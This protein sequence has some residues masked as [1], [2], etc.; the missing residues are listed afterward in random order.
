MTAPSNDDTNVPI[1]AAELL[2]EIRQAIRDYVVLPTPEAEVAVTLWVAATHCIEAFEHAT[3][4]V[5]KSPV[6]GC[7]KSRLLEV[8]H[9]L[10]RQPLS[11]VNISEAALFRSIGIDPPTLLIDE[12]DVMFGTKLKAEQNEGVRGIL[13]AGFRRGAV[14][15]RVTGKDHTPTTFQTFAMAAIAGIGDMPGTIEDRAVVLTMR[16]RAEHERVRG[17]RLKRDVPRLHQL[18]DRLATWGAGVVSVLA[19]DEPV[20]PLEDRPAD[21][22]EPLVA[23]ADAAGGR[24]PELAR[25]AAVTIVE[26]YREHNAST[27]VNIRLL[28]DI[29][30]A[31]EQAGAE[32]ISTDA[33]LKALLNHPDGAWSAAKLNAHQLAAR[34]RGFGVQPKPNA[35]GSKR[36]YRQSACLDAFQRYLP[37]GP[38]EPSDIVTAPRSRRPPGALPSAPDGSDR[39][40]GRKKSTDDAQ[41]QEP[42]TISDTSDDSLPPDED[43]ADDAA[44]GEP[45]GDVLIETVD[46]SAAATA[47]DACD[48]NT[49]GYVDDYALYRQADRALDLDQVMS[50]GHPRQVLNTSN[51]RCPLCILKQQQRQQQEVS[52]DD[53]GPDG[54]D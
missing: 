30:R 11:T 28:S 53:G 52:A 8:L 6:K 12:A 15:I 20:M 17:F 44:N 33:L 23:V 51:L 41:H 50:C 43:I 16:R 22:W 14:T 19:G 21:T 27:D 24:W 47:P 37:G 31:F 49:A 10:C 42:L 5:I 32:F 18:R 38:S 54:R 29:K 46:G 34:L 35:E 13:N 2:D 26:Q 4:L 45:V 3:R 48:V 7:G 1:I 9:E 25:T 36:G 39:Q 40:T